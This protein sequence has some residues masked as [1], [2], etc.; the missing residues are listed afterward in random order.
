MHSC[1]FNCMRAVANC[2]D[3][4]LTAKC[5]SVSAAH[6]CSGTLPDYLLTCPPWKRNTNHHSQQ[7]IVSQRHFMPISRLQIRPTKCARLLLSFMFF[8]HAC[9]RM[10]RVHI[11]HNWHDIMIFFLR[12][13]IGLFDMQSFSARSWDWQV[14]II[15]TPVYSP[16]KSRIACRLG[17]AVVDSWFLLFA[18]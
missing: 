18:V 16:L 13:S 10:A 2:D 5:V 14:W 11:A 9:C 17:A 4:V 8:L 7:I 3:G 6:A 12:F 15:F 1:N